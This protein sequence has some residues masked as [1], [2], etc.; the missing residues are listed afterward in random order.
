MMVKWSITFFFEIPP[1]TKPVCLNKDLLLRKE[2]VWQTLF[3]QNYNFSNKNDI[4][5]CECLHILKSFY[6]V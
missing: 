4:S 5:Y 2:G 3:A 1:C 6:I